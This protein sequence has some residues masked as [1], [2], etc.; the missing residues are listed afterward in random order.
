MTN[1]II[2]MVNDIRD[3]VIFG[4]LTVEVA[5][6]SESPENGCYDVYV[7]LKDSNGEI[8]DC[9]ELATYLASEDKAE[10]IGKFAHRALGG[11]FIHT[12]MSC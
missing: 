6:F 5:Y 11:R 7:N 4:I 3:S 10:E 2:N 1:K 8:S 12:A 9:I